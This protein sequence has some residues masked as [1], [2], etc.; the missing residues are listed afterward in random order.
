MTTPTPA[1]QRRLQETSSLSFRTRPNR[2]R[3]T[4]LPHSRRRASVASNV[5]LTLGMLG[6]VCAFIYLPRPSNDAEFAYAGPTFA[7]IQQ[8]ADLAVLRVQV[9]DVLEGRNNG[10]R[11]ALLV[12]GDYELAVDLA[13]VQISAVDP[14]KRAA[15][16]EL[17]HPRATRP[18]VDHERTRVYRIERTSWIPWVDTRDILLQ[19]SMEQ[20]QSLIAQTA[21]DEANLE[22]ARQHATTLLQAFYRELDWNVSIAWK[23]TDTRDDDRRHLDELESDPSPPPHANGAGAEDTVAAR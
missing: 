22:R 13:Q 8:L 18:R 11:M 10:A 7:E 4:R 12:R 6:A 16:L 17:P 15:T 19:Q 21:T 20:A 2:D 5:V 1:P 23:S 14:E 9:T 3:A